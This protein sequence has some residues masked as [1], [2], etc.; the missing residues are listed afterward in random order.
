MRIWLN[1]PDRWRGRRLGALPAGL[2]VPR[3]LLAYA[4]QFETF[5]SAAW[6][7]TIDARTTDSACPDA[8]ERWLLA[9]FR[10][11]TCQ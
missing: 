3:K 10:S 9:F 5:D 2:R 11:M 7:L 8:D 4:G 1:V 6:T